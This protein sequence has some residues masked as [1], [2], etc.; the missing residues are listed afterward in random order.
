[1]L[2]IQLKFSSAFIP[3]V[4]YVELCTDCDVVIQSEMEQDPTEFHRIWITSIISIRI[5]R[6]SMCP[7]GF[8]KNPQCPFTMNGFWNLLEIWCKNFCYPLVIRYTTLR[9]KR[10]APWK[11]AFLLGKSVDRFQIPVIKY[12]AAG[13]PWPWPWV[14]VKA[15]EFMVR[16][17]WDWVWS[18]IIIFHYLVGEGRSPDQRA[19]RKSR[20]VTPGRPEP[21]R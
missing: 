1:M 17:F 8:H 6:K 11:V 16:F 3:S 10:N 20:R 12:D 14:T 13:V 5:R 18:T 2:Q 4:Y 9:L 15:N 19:S 7:Y 21:H